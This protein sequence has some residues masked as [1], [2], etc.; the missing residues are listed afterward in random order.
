MH[1]D[2]IGKAD[3]VM[4]IVIS[5]VYAADLVSVLYLIANR[6][7]PP[8][9]SKSPM[10][11]VAA[12]VSSV[13]WYCG[14]LVTNGHI[15]LSGTVMANCKAFG[16]WVR[17]LLGVCT[18]SSLIALR[19]YGLYR[20]FRMNLPYR[21]LGF[22]LPFMIYCAC[23]LVYGIVSQ[24]LSTDVTVKY[25]GLMD[26]CYYYDGFKASLFVF[27][28]VT[29]LIVAYINWKIRNIKS[30]FNE[31][32][33]MALSCFVVFAILTFT[34]IMHYTHPMYPLSRTLRLL[35]TSLDHVATNVVW[36]SIMGTPLFNCLFRKQRYL[37]M[38]KRKLRQDG[39]QREYQ[40]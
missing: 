36:W 14:D 19:S 24:V 7:Y 13:A 18:I 27:I 21:G 35:T 37:E 32:R 4:I 34:T 40:I 31:S 25:V 23:L 16:V 3:L 10:L 6:N 8:L 33:E 2:P 17:V 26:L 1:L 5:A 30:S 11:M 39:L 9:K 20:V 12:F 29:W 15:H 28:W 38:W 22:Y